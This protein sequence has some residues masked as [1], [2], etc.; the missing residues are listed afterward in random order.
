MAASTITRDNW[1]NDTGSF[2]VPNG[3]GTVIANTVLQNHIYARIDAMF[4]GTGAYATFTLGGKFAVEGFGVHTFIAGGTGSNTLEL[5]NTTAGTTNFT[6][7]SVGNNSAVDRFLI[8]TYSSTWT[9]SSYAQADG[10]TLFQQGAGGLSIA[11]SNAAGMIRFYSGGTTEQ[12][13][14]DAAGGVMIGT[15]IT[16]GAHQLNMGSGNITV[17]YDGG[18]SPYTLISSTDFEIDNAAGVA[19]ITMLAA[20]LKMATWPTTAAAVNAVVGDTDYIRRSTSVR[21]NKHSIQ[22][23]SQVEAIAAIAAIR[24]VLYRSRVDEDQRL[25]PGFIAEEIEQA[26]PHLA[27]YGPDGALQSV[28]YDRVPAYLVAA[29]QALTDRVSALEAA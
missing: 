22:S 4:A 17:G 5:Q 8:D 26:A 10:T 19:A 1:T 29:V 3:D 18:T 15:T 13:R 6:R 21:A 25:W 23:I 20:G 14:I 7:L 28:A 2:A 24:P 11:A 27:T 12:M 9:S 16:S